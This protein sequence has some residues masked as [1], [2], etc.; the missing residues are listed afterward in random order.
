MVE[1]VLVIRTH[2]ER[3]DPQSNLK[4][5]CTVIHLANK[6]TCHLLSVQQSSSHGHKSLQD[7]TK[8][9]RFYL[10]LMPQCFYGHKPACTEVLQPMQIYSC[11]GLVAPKK[12]S[13]ESLL[14]VVEHKL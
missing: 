11:C 8:W 12:G 13:K 1:R 5:P 9:K 2:E 4:T 7:L 14:S 10:T 6:L 3:V